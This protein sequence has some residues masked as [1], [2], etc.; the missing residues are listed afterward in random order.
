MVALIDRPVPSMTRG[1]VDAML[2]VGYHR[3]RNA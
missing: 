3:F 2:S 1:V